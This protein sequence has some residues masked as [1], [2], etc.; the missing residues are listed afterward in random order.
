VYSLLGGLLPGRSV[1][2][3]G[4]L[5]DIV[6]LPM[7]LQTPSA[8]SVLSL[9]PP[10][11]TLCSV[12]W[13]AESIHLCICQALVK[14]LRIQVYQATVSKHLLAS[15]RVSRFG[16]YIESIPSGAVPGWPFLKSML[17]SL[18]PYLFP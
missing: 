14:S 6:V 11:V 12:Q 17:Y 18:S 3:G 2:W 16:D 1:G 8:P 10:L 15:T 13:L 9:T 4:W 7:G 5:V